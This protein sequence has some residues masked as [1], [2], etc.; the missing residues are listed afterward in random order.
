MFGKRRKKWEQSLGCS[1]EQDGGQFR[2]LVRSGGISKTP[3]AQG[4][5]GRRK[6]RRGERQAR[7]DDSRQA[8]ERRQE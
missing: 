1:G 5:R 2:P 3:A 7:R 6:A 4:G 8:R